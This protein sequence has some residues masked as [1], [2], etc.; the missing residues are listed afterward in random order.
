MKARWFILALA[1]ATMTAESASAH[2]SFSMYDRHR[3]V[4]LSG[5]V[6]EYVWNAPHVT[7]KV[8]SQGGRSNTVTWAVEGS[9]PT[10]LAR[11]GWTSALLKPGDRISVGIHPRKDRTAGGLLADEQQMLVN[12]Q[13]PKGVLSLYPLGDEP[14]VS[15]CAG[16]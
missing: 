12:G 16:L 6:K 10:V 9:S 2:H 3:T 8:L 7:I 1:A 11:G 5:V 13:P 4:T 14:A 15:D